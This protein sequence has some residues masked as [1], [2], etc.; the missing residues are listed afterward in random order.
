MA[1][2]ETVDVA[3]NVYGK[4]Y[5]TLVTLKTLML[6]SGHHIDKIYFVQERQPSWGANCDIVFRNF[7]N[8]KL[9]IPKYFLYIYFAER[10]RYSDED[11]RFSIRYQYAWEHTDKK[12]LFVTHN[13]MLYKSDIIGE[14]LNVLR[15]GEYVGVGQIG[16]C[17]DCPAYHGK[18][19]NGD[20]YSGYTPTYEEVMDLIKKFPHR[21]SDLH[22]PLIDKK[23]PMPLPECRLN[24]MACLIN[25]REIKH[26]VIP[27]GTIDPFGAYVG[28]DLGTKWFKELTMRGYKFKNIDI[29]QYCKHAWGQFLGHETSCN[30]NLYTIAEDEAAAY[31]EDVLDMD[32]DV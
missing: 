15:N 3:I 2:E 16:R 7:D 28:T 23:H 32:L 10:E 1:N 31:L 13:D 8:I 29:Y 26:E 12:Y 20:K 21:K 18:K 4:P 9:F 25:L 24:E 22:D 19:C 5:Q 27:Y 30:S 11:Y 6:H 14:M 17:W